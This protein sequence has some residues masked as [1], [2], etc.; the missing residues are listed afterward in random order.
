MPEHW[1]LGLRLIYVPCTAF[2]ASVA[3]FVRVGGGDDSV[4]LGRMGWA[5]LILLMVSM[6][7]GLATTGLLMLPSDKIPMT[8]PWWRAFWF[9]VVSITVAGIALVGVDLVIGR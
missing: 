1:S 7:G 6:V 5:G 3:A 8:P 4:A 9:L 2:L